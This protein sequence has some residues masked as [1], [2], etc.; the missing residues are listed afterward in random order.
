M[1]GD[2][3]IL[4]E[5]LERGAVWHVRLNSPSANILDERMILALTEMFGK[6]GETPGLSVLCLEGEG[7]HFSFG[8]SVEE[9]LP[10]RVERMLSVFHGMF[11]AALES[12]V[13]LLAAVRGQCLG[14]GLEL[15]SF[16]HRVFSTPDARLG[17]PEIRL[18]VLAPLASLLL[19]ERVGRAAAEDLCL[20]G[21]TISGQEAQVMG[22]VDELHEDPV[23]SAL[24]Y[25]EKALLPHSATSLRHAS[26]ALRLASGKRLLSDLRELESL[27]LEELM[28]SRDAKEGLAAFL[29]K[30]Q[31]VWSH[32]RHD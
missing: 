29:E 18:G 4:V 30:R 20:S 17:Q 27:Y 8:A 24:A 10:G 1:Q 32:I 3:P 7:R 26:R 5:V 28:H 19:R 25:A 14:G 31:P 16:C 6:A 9:H 21:R 13:V 12:S 11:A 2:Q 15:A 23:A 22:L